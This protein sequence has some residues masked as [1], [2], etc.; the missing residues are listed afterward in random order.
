MLEVVVEVLDE[1]IRGVVG[2][3]PFGEGLI[4]GVGGG[5]NLGEGWFLALSLTV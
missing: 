1:L 2:F 3:G 5:G 4:E